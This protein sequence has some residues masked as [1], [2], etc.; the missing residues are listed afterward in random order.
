MGDI[1]SAETLTKN[2]ARAQF[3]KDQ[4]NLSEKYF[5]ANRNRSVSTNIQDQVQN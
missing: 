4:E 2:F 5:L 1:K 3:Q